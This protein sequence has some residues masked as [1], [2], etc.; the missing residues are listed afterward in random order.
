MRELFLEQE[1]C[2]ATG[3]E[4]RQSPPV[5]HAQLVWVD[6]G[7]HVI[8]TR[9]SMLS[10]DTQHQYSKHTQWSRDYI[11]AHIIALRVPDAYPR[12]KLRELLIFDVNIE[13]HNLGSVQVDTPFSSC[14][15]AGQL[16]GD[17]PVIGDSLFAFQCVNQIWAMLHEPADTGF[18]FD[19]DTF[20]VSGPRTFKHTHNTTNANTNPKPKNT[21]KLN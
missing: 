21:R 14:I 8:C 5:L 19:R 11:A 3:N 2:N 18:R 16:V 12:F 20:A 13:P 10:P 7:G 15:P 6:R 1:L 9:S 17:G 4:K